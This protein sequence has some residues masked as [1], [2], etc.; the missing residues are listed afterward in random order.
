MDGAR[1]GGAPGGAIGSGGFGLG[2]WS[3]P[4]DPLSALKLAI[5]TAEAEGVV[6]A[7]VIQEAKVLL[8]T[9]PLRAAM[10]RRDVAGLRTA[11]TVAEGEVEADL[12]VI[13][14]SGAHHR[15][16]DAITSSTI[17]VTEP[18]NAPEP[19]P[20]HPLPTTKHPLPTT[21]HVL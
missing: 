14:V 12:A 2:F 15:G 19:E 8:A 10:E 18:L 5:A 9:Q 13:E 21:H 6:D 4:P 16:S 11:I 20:H 3:R 17:H 1:Q 7:A